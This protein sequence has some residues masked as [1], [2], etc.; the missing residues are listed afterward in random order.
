MARV[1]S[2]GGIATILRLFP[3]SAESAESRQVNIR[4]FAKLDSGI[5]A[6]DPAPQSISMGYA[7]DANMAHLA[8]QVARSMGLAGQ[9]TA[10]H[11]QS[12]WGRV[13]DVLEQDH[14]VKTDAETL[15]ALPFELL[16]DDELR[17]QLQG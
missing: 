15:M 6:I 4:L 11:R 3:A 9:L 2:I 5:L 1:T 14:S 7:D 17:G 13:L 8:D 10:G 16:M 12:F